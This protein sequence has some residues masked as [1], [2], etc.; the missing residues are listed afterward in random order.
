MMKGLEADLS[1]RLRRLIAA[2]GPL[3][4][5]RFMDEALSHPEFGYYKKSDPLGAAGD[6][7][8]APEI[9]QMFGELV[10]LWCG[11]V[12]Q[13]MGSPSPVYL[14]ELGPGRGT[15]MADALRALKGIEGFSKAV[16]VHL[17]ETN[18]VFVKSQRA[19]LKKAGL[20]EP[21]QWHDSVSSLPEGPL[22]LIANEFFD[23]LPIRQFQKTKEGW[24]ERLVDADK[25]GF[26]FVL[27]APMKR[28]P[29]VPEQFSEASDASLFEICP[30]GLGIAAMIGE[31]LSA[32]GGAALVIDYGHE[33]STLGETLQALK[34]HRFHPPLAD[35]GDVDLTAH[36][37]FQA[38]GEAAQTGGARLCG[39]LS[40]GEFLE[41][42]GIG[43]RAEKLAA[44]ATRS[45]AKDIAAAHHRLVDH[46]AMGSLF[47][48][49]AWAHSQL[50][51]PPVFDSLQ[52]G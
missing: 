20:V 5:E 14:V 39:V 11:L 43:L 19:A 49:C 22:L 2:E 25:D 44:K 46:K 36:V 26:H 17:V 34:G 10:G 32:F 7:I 48:V 30:R 15:L 40:Q 9:S 33:K 21:P 23:A 16:R 29:L 37:D 35:P 47:K 6:F 45:Q 38:L 13:S 31:R 42:M 3:G 27:S 51:M 28:M 1:A 18:P 12:W 24:S 52:G 50:S 8:T 41:G 4:L